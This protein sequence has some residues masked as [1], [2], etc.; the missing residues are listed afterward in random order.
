MT[1]REALRQAEAR[2]ASRDIPGVS[3]GQLEALR[4][5]KVE[6]ALHDGRWADAA[7]AAAT[8]RNGRGSATSNCASAS[9]CPV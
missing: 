8:S 5:N 4:R 9:V 1:L 6:P 2:I 3:E 7:M